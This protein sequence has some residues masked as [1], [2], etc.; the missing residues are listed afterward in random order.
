MK[1]RTAGQ[2][3]FTE[4]SFLD[5]LS[6]HLST[7]ERRELLKACSDI[8]IDR[9]LRPSDLL[10]PLVNFQF[11]KT[12]L[13]DFWCVLENGLAMSRQ[14]LERLTVFQLLYISAFYL[15]LALGRNGHDV[16]SD[17]IR[18]SLEKLVG[19]DAESR[20]RFAD[21]LEQLAESKR[22][23][24]NVHLLLSGA[25]Y[26]RL[27]T[28]AQKLKKLRVSYGH[29]VKRDLESLR[30][31]SYSTSF[32]DDW[33]RLREKLVEVIMDEVAFWEGTTL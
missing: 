33:N 1:N 29:L 21:F 2:K 14:T 8:Y 4:E 18:L 28:A 22:D 24:V 23:Y 27:I 9:T 10:A 31:G 17:A 20:E 26:I 30:L 16:A 19:A 3:D 5:Y 6:R 15:Y 13:H 11:P 12:K 7:R 25:A 32:P